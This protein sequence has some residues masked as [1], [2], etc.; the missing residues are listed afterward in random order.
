VGMFFTRFV[1]SELD[2]GLIVHYQTCA[3]VVLPRAHE[4]ICIWDSIQ[5]PFLSTSPHSDV[6]QSDCPGLQ[7]A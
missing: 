2:V 3:P 6:V 1:A 4:I 5:P 7:S